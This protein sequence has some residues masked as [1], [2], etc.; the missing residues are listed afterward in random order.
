MLITWRNVAFFLI[1]SM[2][3][4]YLNQQ[5]I[6]L[7]LLFLIW[8]YFLFFWVIDSYKWFWMGSLHKNIQ[9]MLEFKAPFLDLHFSWYTLMTFL[10]I[11][12]VILLSILMMLLSKCDQAFDLWQQL[13]LASD[14]ESDLWDTVDWD[15]KW[16][17]DFNAGKTQLV[18]FDRSNNNCSIDLKMNGS[19]LEEKPSFKMMGLTFSSKL[20]CGSYIISIAKIAYKKSGAL[21]P[22][23]KFLSPKVALYLYKSTIRPCMRYCCHV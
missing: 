13:E 8:C 20:D 4:G 10:T 23:M 5:Q 1:S 11:L 16:L 14:L 19:V 22:S 6:Y 21:I 17:V 2:A 15:K 12:S 9:L 3:L 18:S 7:Q